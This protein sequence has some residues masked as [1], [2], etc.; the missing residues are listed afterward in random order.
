MSS[1]GVAVLLPSYA[2]T[3][4]QATDGDTSKGCFQLFECLPL[5]KKRKIKSCQHRMTDLAMG[6]S[7]PPPPPESPRSSAS[8]TPLA[9]AG[10]LTWPS[11][12]GGNCIKICVPGKSILRD[13]FQEN[14]TS[15]D[16]FSYSESVFRKDL[17]YTIGP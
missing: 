3:C 5:A 12:S 6:A 8:I 14:R 17:F 11:M 13:Y 7:S 4:P 2:Q 9:Y 16:L 10:P 15:E 1:P